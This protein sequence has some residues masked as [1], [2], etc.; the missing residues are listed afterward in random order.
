[1]ACTSLSS[2]SQVFNRDPHWYAIQT[3]PR[4]E[5]VVSEVLASKGFEHLLPQYKT[6]RKWADR[7]KD[8]ELPLFPRYVFCRFDRSQM[9]PILN[10]PG[11][12]GI[13]RFGRELAP[14]QE[15]EIYR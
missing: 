10:S 5:K 14:L 3:T 6:R 8:L 2:E 4:H 1:M 12:L 15:H 7:I 13:V 11:V 9:V